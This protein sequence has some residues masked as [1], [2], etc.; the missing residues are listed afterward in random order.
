[1]AIHKS[2][3]DYLETILILQK[4]KGKVKSADVANY[5]RYS[6]PSVCNAVDIL[7]RE[8]FLVM[9]EKKYL[10]LTES[11]LKIAEAMYDRH[12]FLTQLFQLLGVEEE[13][14]EKEGCAIEHILSDDSY[15][16]LKAFCEPI[17]SGKVKLHSEK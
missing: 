17:L 8:G 6:R 10:S 4:H 7:Q 1:M 2:G 3:E 14:A 9:D 5:M 15:N 16:K 11:G 13:T 12:V